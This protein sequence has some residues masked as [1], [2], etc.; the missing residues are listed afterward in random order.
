MIALMCKHTHTHCSSSRWLCE[1]HISARVAFEHTASRSCVS[2]TI[3]H[4]GS[5][6]HVEFVFFFLHFHLL[7][8]CDI[9][10]FFAHCRCLLLLFELR[11]M[12]KPNKWIA[13]KETK[14]IHITSTMRQQTARR[15]WLQRQVM[16]CTERPHF[17]GSL[18]KEISYNMREWANARAHTKWPWFDKSH[19]I[20]KAKQYHAFNRP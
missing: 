6:F 3:C 17:Y 14:N 2:L 1:Y 18:N 20:T 15:R 11:V 12:K 16:W 9:M 5:N 10:I 13:K 8:V 7:C 19:I 4:F